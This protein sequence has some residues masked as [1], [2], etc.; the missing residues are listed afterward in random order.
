MVEQAVLEA[1]STA[2]IKGLMEALVAVTAPEI[3]T[4]AGGIKPDKFYL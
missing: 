3:T 1:A 4:S 2:D